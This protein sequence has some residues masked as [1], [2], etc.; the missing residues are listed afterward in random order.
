MV[1]SLGAGVRLVKTEGFVGFVE[2][3]EFIELLEF[4]EIHGDWLRWIQIRGD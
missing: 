1:N 4:P 2:F 3:I